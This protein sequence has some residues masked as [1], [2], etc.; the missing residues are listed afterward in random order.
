LYEA[1]RRKTREMEFRVMSREEDDDSTPLYHAAT[2]VRRRPK[3]RI[4]MAMPTTVSVVLSLWRKAF[5]MM[6]FN[7]NME[8]LPRGTL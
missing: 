4:A 2:R 1:G 3:A 7:T 5:R 8:G 6:S